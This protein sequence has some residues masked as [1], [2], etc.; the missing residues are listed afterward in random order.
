M[1]VKKKDAGYLT[2]SEKKLLSIIGA[3]QKELKAEKDKNKHI[4]CFFQ[5]KIADIRAELCFTPVAMYSAFNT[6]QLPGLT[7]RKRKPVAKKLTRSSN[8]FQSPK[9]KSRSLRSTFARRPI[10]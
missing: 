10:F 9:P 4:H 6:P 7:Q 2:N 1:K 3:L 5:K 8:T